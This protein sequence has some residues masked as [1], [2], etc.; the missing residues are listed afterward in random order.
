MIELSDRNSNFYHFLTNDSTVLQFLIQSL[1]NV[2]VIVQ[3]EET[4]WPRLLSLKDHEQTH[5]WRKIA[6][7][8]LVRMMSCRVAIPADFLNFCLSKHSVIAASLCMYLLKSAKICNTEHFHQITSTQHSMHLIYFFK[9][10]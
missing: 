10:I 9:W 3:Q 4:R 6:F 2:Y 1:T 8:L 7:P 5:F